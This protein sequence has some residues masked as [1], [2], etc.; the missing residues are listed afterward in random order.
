MKTGF[1][2]IQSHPMPIITDLF[3]LPPLEY[4]VAVMDH[5]K[6]WVDLE[7]KYLK[8]TYCNRTQVRLTNKVETLIIPIKKLN[9]QDGLADV[10]IDYSQKWKNV[11][12]R[13]FQSGYGKAPFYEYFFPYIETVY[14]K[15]LSNLVEF[16]IEL[17]TVCLELLQ[18]KIP[19]SKGMP[20]EKNHF[21]ADIRGT[22]TPKQDFNIRNIYKAYPYNQ[23]FGVNFVPNLSVLDLLFCAGPDSREILV[24]S[25]KM[26]EQSVK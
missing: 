22:I 14:Q 26:I 15:N 19:V 9:S 10:K 2:P 25:K 8:P 3:Y 12:L 1:I 17:L 6:I 23:L 21:T 13:G 24:N 7:G 16:N 18:L 11:H 20:N 5:N 4:F